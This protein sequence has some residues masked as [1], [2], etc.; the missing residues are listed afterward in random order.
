LNAESNASSIVGVPEAI[1]K[2]QTAFWEI[3]AAERH[4]KVTQLQTA[5]L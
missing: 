1:Q 4:F 3:T 5:T 2:R